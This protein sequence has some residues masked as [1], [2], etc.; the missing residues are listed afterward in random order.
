MLQSG[1]A[2]RA[3]AV[4]GA[5]RL[6]AAGA[7]AKGGAAAK[8]KKV[9]TDGEFWQFCRFSLFLCFFDSVPSSFRF[10]N[11]GVV[12][13]GSVCLPLSCFLCMSPF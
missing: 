13:G 8:T 3:R 9:R 1:M 7:S 4:Q 11:A 5:L 12:L 10:C 2:A 6:R